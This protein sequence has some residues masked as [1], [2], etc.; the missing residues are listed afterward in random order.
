MSGYWLR[1]AYCE[2][3]SR[4]HLPSEGKQRRP[5]PGAARLVLSQTMSTI[6]VSR[7][8]AHLLCGSNGRQRW[9]HD[10]YNYNYNYHN[11]STALSR[12]ATGALEILLPQSIDASS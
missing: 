6:S 11:N 4:R 3:S 1:R 8:G 2:R 7:I 9:T 5:I 10:S 12:F